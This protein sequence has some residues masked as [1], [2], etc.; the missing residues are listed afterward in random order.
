MADLT[1]DFANFAP[2]GGISRRAGAF[3][4]IAI[5]RPAKNGIMA[6]SKLTYR[7]KS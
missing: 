5:R 7:S 2:A 1:P 4:R 3:R 6:P